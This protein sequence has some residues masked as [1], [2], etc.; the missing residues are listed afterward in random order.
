M[1]GVFDDAEIAAMRTDA[2]FILELVINSSLANGRQSGRLDIRR[3]RDGTM[4]VRKIQPIVDL[5]LALA[6]ASSD[7]RLLEPMADLMGDQPVLM[8]KS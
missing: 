3:Q 6:E 5:A 8:K 2:D 1:P 4:V 7:D